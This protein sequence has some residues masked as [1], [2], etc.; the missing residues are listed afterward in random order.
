MTAGHICT[1]EL[2]MWRQ[3]DAHVTTAQIRICYP[4]NI[5][6][7]LYPVKKLVGGFVKGNNDFLL[8]ANCKRR[9]REF[10]EMGE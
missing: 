9:Q 2:Q 5:E 3:E 10:Q 8:T 4:K 1:L 6:E 7:C